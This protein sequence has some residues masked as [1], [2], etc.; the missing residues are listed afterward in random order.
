LGFD[1]YKDFS[2]LTSHLGLSRQLNWFGLMLPK[3][4]TTQKW[5]YA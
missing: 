3:K 4:R 5:S 2:K 1:Y